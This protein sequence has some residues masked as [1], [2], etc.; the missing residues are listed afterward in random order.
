MSISQGHSRRD[1]LRHAATAA[2][3]MTAHPSLAPWLHAARGSITV[4]GSTRIEMLRLLGRPLD[5]NVLKLFRVIADPL[6]NRL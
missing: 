6:R 2:A 5:H 3:V 1:F 4:A